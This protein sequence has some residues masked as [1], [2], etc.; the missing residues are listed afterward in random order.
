MTFLPNWFCSILTAFFV[1]KA[2]WFFRNKNAVAPLVQP[3]PQTTK[4]YFVSQ[5]TEFE[6]RLGSPDYGF[7]DLTY[8][9][10]LDRYYDVYLPEDQPVTLS[11]FREIYH[12]WGITPKMLDKEADLIDYIDA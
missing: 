9:E 7:E 10:V 11:Q 3:T 8:R 6:L 4:L 1:N 5:G 2:N 12:D